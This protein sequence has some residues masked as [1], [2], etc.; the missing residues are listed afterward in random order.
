RGT[1]IH[2]ARAERIFRT[3]DHVPR[4]IRTARQHL[5]RRRPVR[6]FLLGRNRLR[7]RPCEA[8]AADADAVAQRTAVA[9]HQVQELVR[10]IDHDRAG[11]FLAAILDFLLFVPG[12]EWTLRLGSLVLLQHRTRLATRHVDLWYV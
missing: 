11:S 8:R 7:P 4:Q 1:E 12:I 10:R 2:R 5:R 6:P 9:L 3:A